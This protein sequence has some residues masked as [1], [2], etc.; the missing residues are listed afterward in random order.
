MYS[1]AVYSTDI[2]ANTY[3][4]NTGSIK[5]AVF[6]KHIGSVNLKKYNF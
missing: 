4:I 3:F 6:A 5:A 1:A 2:I